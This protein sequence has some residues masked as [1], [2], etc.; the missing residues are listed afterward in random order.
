MI[1]SPMQCRRRFMASA[2]VGAAALIGGTSAPADEGGPP[3][4]PTIRLHLEETPPDEVNCGAPIRLAKELLS[5]EGFADIRDVT[6]KAGLAYTQ[7]FSRGEIDFGV[8]F[9]SGILRR[10]EAGIPIT[11]LAG[12]HSGCFELFAH[13]HIRTFTDLRGKRVGLG[14]GRGTVEEWFVSIMAA[15]VG[16]NP[17]TDIQW[18]TTDD[19]AEPM[20]LF[21]QGRIDAYLAYVSEAQDLRARK[22]G[23]V[24]M[25]MGRDKLFANCFCCMIVGRA[26]FVQRYPVATKRALRAI[27]KATDLCSTEPER[28]ARQLVEAGLAQHY[29]LARQTLIDIPYASW[30]ELDPEDTLRFYA[31]WLYEFRE[32]N[33]DPNKLLA[34][35]GDWRF[36]EQIRREL[37]I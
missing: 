17:K 35:G 31:L 28:A 10:L 27:L 32:L 37:K 19:V 14:T 6:T 25:D 22:I 7:A 16:L 30:R 2:A 36:L 26:D 13:E 20:D 11:A 4:T 15:W 9:P 21:V 34:K 23:H 1:E 18:I 3:E 29:D 12:M 8:M 33:S 24:I 5:A